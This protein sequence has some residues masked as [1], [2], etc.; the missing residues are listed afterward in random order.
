[1]DCIWVFCVSVAVHC[2]L[3]CAVEKGHQMM[4]CDALTRYRY[5]RLSCRLAHFSDLPA[6]T[7]DVFRL[8]VLVFLLR[9]RFTYSL[10][11]CVMESGLSSE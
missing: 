6:L 1:M 8:L 11:G 10:G 7:S 3:R 5:E 9:T 4:F 2:E